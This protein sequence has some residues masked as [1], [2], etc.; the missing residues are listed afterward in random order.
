MSRDEAKLWGSREESPWQTHMRLSKIGCRNHLDT[1]YRVLQ[2]YD[3]KLLLELFVSMLLRVG[4]RHKKT[5]CKN[6]LFP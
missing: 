3:Y 6:V 1:V 5:N 4:H 2:D